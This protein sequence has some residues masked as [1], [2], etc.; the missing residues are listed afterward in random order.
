M[1]KVKIPSECPS[2]N[3]IL[4]RVNNQLFCRNPS[5]GQQNAKKVANYAKVLKIKGLGDKTVEKLGL[6]S[7]QDIY[8]LTNDYI[9]DTIGE[10]LGNKLIEEIEKTKK[11]PFYMFIAA[12]GIPLIGLTAAKKLMHIDNPFDLSREVCKNAG[13]G[14]KATNNLMNW[15]TEEYELNLVDLPIEFTSEVND[16]SG[17][18][19]VCI[20]GKVAGYTKE[21]LANYLKQYNVITVND[22]T[23][24]TNYLICETKKG[25]TKENKATK[26]S[27]PIVTLKEFEE[28]INE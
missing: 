7:I 18:I 8:K 12:A 22:V 15:I 2:C 3:S 14:D 1:E 23:K 28:I 11:I 9:I 26:L 13:L 19:K 20:T 4:I 25:S 24:D 27:I 6:S 21:T 10:K 16:N 17:N 5:C